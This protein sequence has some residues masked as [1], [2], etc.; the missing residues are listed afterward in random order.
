M[1]AGKAIPAEGR[2]SCFGYVQTYDTRPKRRLFEAL[3][4]QCMHPNQ[5]ITFL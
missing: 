5:Q 3:K 1:I 2:A 4:S